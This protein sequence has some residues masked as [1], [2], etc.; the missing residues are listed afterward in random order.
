MGVPVWWVLAVAHSPR[1]TPVAAAAVSLCLM[2]DRAP[3]IAVM[4]DVSGYRETDRES[5]TSSLYRV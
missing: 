4:I 3:L 1:V 2:T 5:L